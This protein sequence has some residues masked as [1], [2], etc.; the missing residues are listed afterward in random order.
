MRAEQ[1]QKSSDERARQDVS[2]ALTV[3]EEGNGYQFARDD[4]RV[5]GPD[6]SHDQVII[7]ST[8]KLPR[9]FP[10]LCQKSLTRHGSTGKEYY[11]AMTIIWYEILQML[12]HSVRATAEG[13]S[14]VAMVS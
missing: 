2:E 5:S 3:M 6:C 10:L 9:S 8:C 4:K 14:R 13:Q 12:T 1:L 7:C 11:H